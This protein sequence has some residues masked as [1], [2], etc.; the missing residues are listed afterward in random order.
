MQ[1]PDA[2]RDRVRRP[3]SIQELLRRIRLLEDHTAELYR[4]LLDVKEQV[5]A[6]KRDTGRRREKG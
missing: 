4:L 5:E 3:V 6:L 1:P 2:W